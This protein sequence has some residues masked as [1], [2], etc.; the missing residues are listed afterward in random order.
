MQNQQQQQ[1][2][3]QFHKYPHPYFIVCDQT[4]GGSSSRNSSNNN[5][6]NRPNRRVNECL[7]V[8]EQVQILMEIST[9]STLL[10]RTWVGWSPLW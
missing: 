1:Q 2:Q 7:S 5:N 10:S 6:N 4:D 8:E 3:P 9:N